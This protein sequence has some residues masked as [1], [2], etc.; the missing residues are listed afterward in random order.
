MIIE[1]FDWE[2]GHHQDC[3]QPIKITCEDEDEEIEAA[4]MI[5]MAIAAAISQPGSAGAYLINSE[6]LRMTYYIT[7][8]YIR[9]DSD[10][11]P[12]PSN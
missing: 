8:D 3:P 5:L 9:S 12:V 1:F 6:E 2:C 7:D 4:E 10:W 11:E